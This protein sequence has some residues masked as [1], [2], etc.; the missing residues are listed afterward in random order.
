LILSRVG[1]NS[2]KDQ[3]LVYAGKIDAPLAGSGG[4]YFLIK[5]DGIWEVQDASG[6]W[7]S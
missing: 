2:R 1:F 4:Y 5:E 6:A 7:I 3:A